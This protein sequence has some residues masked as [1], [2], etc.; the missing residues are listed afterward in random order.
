MTIPVLSN[1]FQIAVFDSGETKKTV[2]IYSTVPLE[3]CGIDLEL[4]C[5]YLLH[6]A[7]QYGHGYEATIER[8]IE[9]AMNVRTENE[10]RFS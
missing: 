6:K 4:A 9:E 3:D 1:I 10:I 2:A 8:I 7:A 5:A